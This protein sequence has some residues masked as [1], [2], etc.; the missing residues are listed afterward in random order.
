MTVD[1]LYNKVWEQIRF[2]VRFRIQLQFRMTQLYVEH[3][4][5]TRVH[6]RVTTQGW[7]PAFERIN[8]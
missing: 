4:I 8:R 5:W 7:D 6:N 1:N 3:H 2:R